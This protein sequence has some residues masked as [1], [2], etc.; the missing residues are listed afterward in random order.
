MR[1]FWNTRRQYDQTEIDDA[2][3]TLS[4]PDAARIEW[5][6]PRQPV[7]LFF[8]VVL[9]I[10]V[11]LLGRLIFL[12]VLRGGYYS[13]M[14]ERNSLR[15]I[16]LAA[17]RG[18]IFDRSGKP[19]VKN[20]PSLDGLIIPASLPED[21]KE[22]ERVLDTAETIF[23][24]ESN[25]WREVLVRQK[26]RPG[27][28]FIVKEDISQEQTIVY[29]SQ[30]SS[31]PGIGLQKSARREYINGPMFAHV[32]G[33]E[34]KIRKEELSD[35]PDYLFT[36][37]I[38]KQGVERSYESVLRG[39]HGREIVEV[40]SMGRVQK[41]LGIVPP[42]PGNNITL[43]IDK[44]LSEKLYT[45]LADWFMAND[46]KAGAAI[47][48]DPRSGAIRALISYP[49]FD[50]NLFSGG[51]EQSAYSA[52][53]SDEWK[54]LFNRAIGGEYPPGSTL[55]PVLAAAA[56]AEH[57]V[58]PETSIESRGGI[59]V[60]KF[61]FGDWKVHGFTDLRR[62]IAVSSDVYFYTLGGGYGGIGGL[63]MERMK[64]YEERFGYGAK[65]GVDLTGEADGFLPDPDWKE[66]KIGERWYIGDDYNS[67]IGQGYI[68]ATPLQ[69]INSIAAIANGGTLYT[70]HVR[71]PERS[72]LPFPS[73]SVDVSTDI[74]RVVRE[75]MR[76]TVTEGTA[77]SLQS[78]PV[79]VAGKTGTAQYGGKESTHGWFVSFAPYENPE[80]ALIVLVEGQTKESTYHAVPITKAIYEWYF[81]DQKKP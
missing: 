62:A 11:I 39:S 31:L 74:L 2:V 3:L 68:T 29:Y 54:P 69:I 50:N 16:V 37:S 14:A 35:H 42:K 59:N 8:V 48:I 53:I 56:L 47:A 78:L 72:D 28:A 52:L 64:Q 76:E 77:Q 15:S 80:L 38:G 81:K 33:Y 61:F 6:L 41:E 20:T 66:R 43:T 18:I 46:L 12:N 51:I 9:L 55:K 71:S 26:F 23:R 49:S 70:P 73:R 30:A 24:P 4:R 10:L 7:R 57:I 65:T 44:D 27:E 36:D 34:G 25:D 60:G 75:G 79:A 63:G 22:R 17:P 21:S 45:T 13:E 67:S 32:L 58:T 40:D 19:L 5:V 1:F